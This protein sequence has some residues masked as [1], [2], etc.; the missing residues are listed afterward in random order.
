MESKMTERRRKGGGEQTAK[1]PWHLVQYRF[2][3]LN[4]RRVPT[5]L[6][7]EQQRQHRI[8]TNKSQIVT[9]I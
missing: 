7:L 4:V 2:D 1:Y 5:L 8:S 3:L 6:R 9:R